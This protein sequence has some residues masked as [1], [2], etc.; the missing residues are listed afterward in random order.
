M[1][2][3]V[4]F[5][6][7][8]RM[9]KDM[10][11]K[12]KRLL[13]LAFTILACFVTV[14]VWGL[15]TAAASG[16]ASVG[17]ISVNGGKVYFSAEDVIYLNSELSALQREVNNSVSGGVSADGTV[18]DSADERRKLINSRGTINYDNGKVVAD[19]ASLLALA[20]RTDALA[21]SYATAVC[22]A[23]NRIGTFYDAGGNV[24]HESQTAGSI[25]LSREQLVSGILKSQSVDHTAAAPVI[26]DNITAGAAAW[27]NGRCI[28]GN[29][30]DNERAYKRGIED[31][32]NGDGDGIDMEYIYHVHRNGEGEEV[33]QLTVY[34]TK[35][36]GGCYVA[37]GHTHN[38]GGVTCDGP[39]NTIE[40]R[41][42]STDPS[43]PDRT[44]YKAVCTNCGA[45]QTQMDSL[46]TR[47]SAC[48][49]YKCNK[50][51][52]NTWK[53]GCG[54]DIGDIESVIIII[55]KDHEAGE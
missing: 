55:R 49:G 36:Q 32:E 17:N 21:D 38:K 39:H 4:S 8:Q 24:N 12:R 33:S 7:L 2:E 25:A 23:L 37:A 5:G 40:A 53:I 20:D 30:A 54:K 22:R 1:S 44:V 13:V 51:P 6:T 19:E 11:M 15:K 28:I 45:D 10:L 34:D 27:V 29:G 47:C 42:T 35:T 43:Y 41:G 18:H 31:G 3:Y 48:Q 50:K 16:T 26:A 46:R 9:R 14:G 52:V